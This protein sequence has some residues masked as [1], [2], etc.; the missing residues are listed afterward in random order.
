MVKYA[1]ELEHKHGLLTAFFNLTYL[2]LLQWLYIASIF[3]NFYW[4]MFACCDHSYHTARWA[5]YAYTYSPSFL[6]VYAAFVGHTPSIS[7]Y[8]GPHSS[9]IPHRAEL[10]TLQCPV[11]HSAWLNACHGV[12]LPYINF[13]WIFSKK[14]GG[15]FSYPFSSVQF[16]P[17]V[18]SNSLWPLFESQYARPPCPSPTIGMLFFLMTF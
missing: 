13:D 4:S 18:V 17:S 8:R 9:S 3:K 2:S 7:H 11:C 5:S 1:S 6:D 16:S 12:F 14:Y 10:T 15:R